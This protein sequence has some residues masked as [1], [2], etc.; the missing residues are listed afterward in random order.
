[1]GNSGHGSVSM[2]VKD[3]GL[4]SGVVVAAEDSAVFGGCGLGAELKV[5][6]KFPIEG[7]ADGESKQPS[8]TETN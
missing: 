5:G 2:F 1:M 3:A 4:P 6:D 7:V 8:K